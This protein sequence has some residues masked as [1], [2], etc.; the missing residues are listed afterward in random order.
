MYEAGSKQI[1]GLP[2]DWSYLCYVPWS[3]IK[4]GTSESSPAYYKTCTNATLF[5]TW[6]SRTCNT[7]FLIFEELQKW[8]RT[9]L[10]IVNTVFLRLDGYRK[11]VKILDLKIFE[12]DVSGVSV[13]VETCCS[14]TREKYDCVIL[15]TQCVLL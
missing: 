13:E 10:R 1:V 2:V 4:R 9:G 7:Q 11:G 12:I 14:I 3:H 15:C 6:M 5:H 8:R